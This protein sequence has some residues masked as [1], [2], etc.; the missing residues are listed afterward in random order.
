M[1]S[2]SQPIL[3]INTLAG[4]CIWS[5]VGKYQ[6]ETPNVARKASIMGRSGTQRVAMVT[7]LLDLYCGAHLVES[8]CQELILIQIGWDISFHQIWT[9]PG[10]VYDV[11]TSAI[12]IF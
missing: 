12:C 3:Y 5:A 9:K 8:Y 1:T 7:K 6:N 4:S 11:I 10:W 2:Y